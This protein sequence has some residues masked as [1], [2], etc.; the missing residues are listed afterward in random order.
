LRC[1]VS[2][3]FVY[4][5]LALEKFKLLRTAGLPALS[6]LAKTKLTKRN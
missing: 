2:S 1:V 4:A 5:R 6:L 3:L